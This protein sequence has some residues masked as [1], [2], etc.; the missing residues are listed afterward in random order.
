MRIVSAWSRIGWKKWNGLLGNMIFR[1]LSIR[2]RPLRVHPRTVAD[3]QLRRLRSN[4]RQDVLNGVHDTDGEEMDA[5]IFRLYVFRLKELRLATIRV[6][7]T[8]RGR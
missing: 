5:Y 8:D 6:R 4:P 3:G 2:Q 1:Q 7:I